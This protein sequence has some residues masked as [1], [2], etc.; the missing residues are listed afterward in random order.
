[1]SVS[2]E[3]GSPGNCLKAQ[4]GEQTAWVCMRTPL[5]TRRSVTRVSQPFSKD[6]YGCYLVGSMWG[7]KWALDEAQHSHHIWTVLLTISFVCSFCSLIP[8]KW[9]QE[10]SLKRRTNPSGKAETR[11]HV[12][13]QVLFSS[14]QRRQSSLSPPWSLHC[15]YCSTEPSGD[16]G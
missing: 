16:M 4:S 1:M 11:L 7:A 5:S 13:L 9:G 15:C 14:A 2:W 8:C 6:D 12:S 10:H 3:A